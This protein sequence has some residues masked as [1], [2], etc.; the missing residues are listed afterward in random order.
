[1]CS[2]RLT[3]SETPS[4]VGT[5]SARYAPYCCTRPGVDCGASRV[6]PPPTDPACAIGG[7]A[8]VF[9]ARAAPLSDAPETA[10]WL[11]S[12][13]VTTSTAAIAAAA[14]RATTS[15]RRHVKRLVGADAPVAAIERTCARSSAGAAMREPCNSAMRSRCDMECLLELLECAVEPRGAVGGGDA[16]HAR[17]GRRIHVEDD[18]QRNHLALSGGEC[19]QSRFEVRRETFGEVLFDALVWRGE[20]LAP[21]AAALGAEVVERDGARDL[22][23]PGLGRPARGV[24][25]VPEPQRPLEP[26]E[27]AVHI[28]E[29]LLGSLGKRHL[30]CSTPPAGR[31]SRNS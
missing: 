3:P 12:G 1:M 6:A 31:S 16:E 15:A 8:S 4:G 24:E 10:V 28:V 13:R 25:A 11:L 2:A 19:G 21:R 17:R 23:E 7:A 26:G 29:V 9:S 30:T 18:A 27:V 22:T 20:L 5:R 14:G